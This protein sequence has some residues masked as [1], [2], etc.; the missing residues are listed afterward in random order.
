MQQLDPALVTHPLPAAGSRAGAGAGAGAVAGAGAG[1]A[2]PAQHSTAC[3]GGGGARRPGLRDVH[4]E[5]GAAASTAAMA[6]RGRPGHAPAGAVGAGEGKR[7]VERAAYAREP[8][9]AG[10]EAGVGNGGG[11]GGGGEAGGMTQQRHRYY[12]RGPLDTAVKVVQ[13]E[14]VRGLFK[15]LST[16]MLRV[17]PSAAITFV[18]YEHVSLLLGATT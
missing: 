3:S 17:V 1:V 2:T 5:Q 12:Y 14:G 9:S 13:G 16:N 7:N 8:V 4:D 10:R 6:D 15:G 18:V 11:A